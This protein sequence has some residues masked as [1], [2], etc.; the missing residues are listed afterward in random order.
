MTIHARSLARNTKPIRPL[1]K[2][3]VAAA[4]LLALYGTPPAA[5][6]DA[7]EPSN[8]NSG[9]TEVIVTATRHKETTESIAGAISV[10]SPDEIAQASVT[11]IASLG[12]QMGIA[13]ASGAK[14]TAITFPIIRGLNASPAAGSFHVFNQAPVATYYD[15]SPVEGYY[16]LQ[17]IQ[18]IEVL[19]GPQG[20]LYGAGSLGG[21]LR[22]IPNA[23]Q[24]GKFAGDVDGRVGYLDHAGHPTYT[25]TAMLN[26]PVGDTLAIRL[27]GNYEYQPGYIDAFGLMQRS[28]PLG[29][30]VLADPS[31]PVNSPG[32]Y[33][34]QKDWNDQKTFTGRASVL[35]QP[36]QEFSAT[37]AY[38]HERAYGNGTPSD[39][40]RFQGGPDVI[41]PRIIF[42]AGSNFTTYSSTLQPFERNS[43]LASLDLSYDAGFATLSATSTYSA[44]KGFFNTDTNFLLFGLL[45]SYVPF[46]AGI[47]TNPRWINTNLSS[48][49]DHGFS[50]EVRLV[51]NTGPDK[52]FDYTVGVFYQKKYDNA[53]F[54][55]SSPG[56]PERAAAQTDCPLLPP[57]SPNLP[58]LLGG[59][60]PLTGPND[61]ANIQTDRQIFEDKS[62]FGELTYHF[63]KNWQATA[64]VRHFKQD[65]T[66]TGQYDL[67]TFALSVPLNT[68]VATATKTLGKAS[69]GWEYEPNQHVYAL[70][71]QG[72][73]RGG[74]NGQLL[75][76]GA[77][78]DLAPPIYKPD[79]VN[80]YEIGTKGRIGNEISYSFD[81]F[82]VA[83]KDPQ[84]SG[85]TP[86][87]NFAVWNAK[88]AVSKGFEY[89]LNV[90]LG[91]PGLRLA[92]SG[93][94]ADA[95]LTQDYSYPDIN[96]PIAGPNGAQLPGSPKVSVAGT[97]LY[98]HP[99]GARSNMVLTLNDTYTSHIVT[100]A[101]PVLNIA[102]ITIPALNLVNASAVYNHNNWRVGLYSTNL[103]NKREILG[104]SSGGPQLTYTETANEPREFYLRGGYSF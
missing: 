89:E 104:Q 70:W 32:V 35:W 74:A 77:F 69:I 24:L 86:Q 92:T 88:E 72:F 68:K 15:N 30:P 95:K 44:T 22:I 13:G 65:F 64:G 11:D 81:V 66:D 42:P 94:Y 82:Y 31:D 58:V 97:L 46:Y 49:D 6:A 10:V 7:D 78:A 85:L 8:Q 73:R 79:F 76:S 80:N 18:R 47:P 28:G 39:N 38:M 83:W 26:I 41:D 27:A 48:D 90:P 67:Y 9:L 36:T 71:S 63:A 14:A 100:S 54:A 17:D 40:S 96:G 34:S 87:A 91:L 50:Q 98:S 37:A 20:T 21:A 1:A 12:R 60:A 62:V 84:V 45:G 2:S 23:P 25:T 56:T 4:V 55:N 52:L 5:R 57:G 99:L 3:S 16:Q 33:Y 102:P 29:I 59:C 61:I 51:S 93:T 53:T 101:F 43:D 103:F 19:R 75:S